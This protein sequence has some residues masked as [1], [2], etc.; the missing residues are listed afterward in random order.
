MSRA[1]YPSLLTRLAVVERFVGGNW[2]LRTAPWQQNWFQYSADWMILVL[3][4]LL[5]QHTEL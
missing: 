2:A 5:W 4:T 1:T 3:Q